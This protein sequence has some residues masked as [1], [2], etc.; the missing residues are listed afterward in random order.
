MQSLTVVQCAYH[1]S[2]ITSI[3]NFLLSNTSHHSA[4]AYHCSLAH[5]NIIDW[6][7]YHWYIYC[8]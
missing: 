6:L 8:D 5:Y 4:V 2:L 3:T 7:M 1:Y